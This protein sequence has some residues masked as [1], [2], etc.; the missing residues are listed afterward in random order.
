MIKLVVVHLLL[1]L[2]T[3]NQKTDEKR[4]EEKKVFEEFMEVVEQR[5][6]LVAL[7]EEDRLKYVMLSINNKLQASSFIMPQLKQKNRELSISEEQT[8]LI[9]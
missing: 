9:N 4:E 8:S 3:D 6:A 1:L 7:L 2:M 5:N